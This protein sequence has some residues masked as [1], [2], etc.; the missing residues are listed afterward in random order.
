LGFL[1][2]AKPLLQ[3][4]KLGEKRKG[5]DH[6]QGG[7]TT[8]NGEPLKW[9]G[10]VLFSGGG[11]TE[12]KPKLPEKVGEDGKGE[13]TFKHTPKGKK[14]LDKWG[15]KGKRKGN[16]GKSLVSKKGTSGLEIGEETAGTG[17]KRQPPGRISAHPTKNVQNQLKVRPRK[18]KSRIRYTSLGGIRAVPA[19]RGGGF[20]GV[21]FWVSCHK[22]NG[23]GGWG[24]GGKKA[25][26]SGML[27]GFGFGFEGKTISKVELWGQPRPG[28]G[29]GSVR[30]N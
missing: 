26:L 18:E 17:K 28:R 25:K 10:G 6:V 24:V 1:A 15:S 4:G 12:K 2:T 9:G 30:K 29:L 7:G 14:V 16:R 19:A 13:P 11:G 23:W 3:K 8:R 20:S 22:S 5:G 27:A 21:F